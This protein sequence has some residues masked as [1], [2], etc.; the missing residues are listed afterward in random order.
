MSTVGSAAEMPAFPKRCVRA[1]GTTAHAHIVI[2]S[3]GAL[4]DASCVYDHPD[5]TVT[6]SGSTTGKY[7]ITFPPCLYVRPSV[8]YVY[9]S[10]TTLLVTGCAAPDAGAGTWAIQFATEAGAGAWPASTDQFDL[11]LDMTTEPA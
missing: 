10:S 7:T 8:S 5:I 9:A 1:T 4:T 6:K 2:G 11:C 3:S